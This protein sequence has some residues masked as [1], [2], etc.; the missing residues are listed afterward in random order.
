[1]VREK[2]EE[3]KQERGEWAKQGSEEREPVMGKM[4]QGR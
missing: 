2:M 3:G 1:M 4:K